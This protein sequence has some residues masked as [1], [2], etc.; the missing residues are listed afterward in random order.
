MLLLKFRRLDFLEY[1]CHWVTS[2]HKQAL[3]IGSDIVN[4][5]DIVTGEWVHVFK[6]VDIDENI[7][8]IMKRR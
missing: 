8:G 2:P 3:Y 5:R 7:I 6:V 4:R 1:S